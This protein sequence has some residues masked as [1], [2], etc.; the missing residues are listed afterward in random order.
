MKPWSVVKGISS[1][2]QRFVQDSNL[3][4][5][6]VNSNVEEKNLKGRGF[7]KKGGLKKRRAV[8]LNCFALENKCVHIILSQ[9]I[10]IQLALEQHG[11][12]LFGP[13]YA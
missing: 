11:F 10:Y 2:S 8:Y 5:T 3:I 6:N 9:Q 7:L 12:E 1:L 13:T 4:K